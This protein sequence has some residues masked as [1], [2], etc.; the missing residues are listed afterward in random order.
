MSEEASHHRRRFLGGAAL[1]I[2][3]AQIGSVRRPAAAQDGRTKA[4]QL[5]AAKPG[6]NTSFASLQQN[7]AGL[8]NVGYAEAGPPDDRVVIILHGC[9]TTF[10][11]MSTSPLCWPRQG[12][13]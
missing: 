3:A 2:A 11:A 10:T 9:P 8:L 6:T 12:I 1:T 5:P 7:D 13:G 4:A